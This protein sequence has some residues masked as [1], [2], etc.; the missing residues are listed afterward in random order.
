MKK[1]NVILFIASGMKQ[2]KKDFINIEN[3]NLYLNYG[4]LGLATEEDGLLIKTIIG[5][6]IKFQMWIV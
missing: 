5:L 4:L 2:K 1:E 3:N 6:R